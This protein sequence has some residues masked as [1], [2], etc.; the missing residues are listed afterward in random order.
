MGRSRFLHPGDLIRG[1]NPGMWRAAAICAI[2]LL[3]ACGGDDQSLLKASSID[4]LYSGASGARFSIAN[5]DPAVRATLAGK[6]TYKG[7]RRRSIVDMSGRP[8]CVNKHPKGLL[9]EDFLV[10]D[11]GALGGVVIYIKKGINK[12]LWETPSEPVI[13]DQIDCQYVP[14]L[15]FVRTGQPLV[16]KSSDDTLHNVYT[17]PTR[18]PGFNQSMSGRGTLNPKVYSKAEIKEFRCDVHSWMLGYAAIMAHPCYAVSAADGTFTIKDIPPGTYL[19][20]AWH[21]RLTPVTKE[22]T[23]GD[24]EAKTLDFKFKDG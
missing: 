6:I 8:F 3:V 15:V 12:R 14:H 1:L 23:I 2:G 19:V 21:E 17:K 10:G 7:R 16:I 5:A 22:I 20:E 13:F 18:N 4:E 24:N 11:E 9:S